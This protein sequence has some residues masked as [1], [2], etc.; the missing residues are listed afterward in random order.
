MWGDEILNLKW[1]MKER[2]R[3]NEC[4]CTFRFDIDKFYGEFNDR[5]FI[6]VVWDLID[7]SFCL[8]NIC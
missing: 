4:F 1:S 6:M 3:K 5:D 8:W 7:R 2:K